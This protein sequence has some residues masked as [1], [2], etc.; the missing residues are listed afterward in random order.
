M[1]PLIKIASKLRNRKFSPSEVSAMLCLP[2]EHINNLFDEVDGLGI[3]E[4]GDGKRRI[5][6]R[7]LFTLLMAKRLIELGLAK[8]VRRRALGQALSKSTKRVEPTAELSVLVTGF[9]EQAKAA[10][11]SLYEAEGN[12][13][14]SGEI[15]QGEPCLRDTRVSVYVL[16]EI[17]AKHGIESARKTYSFLD[18]KQIEYAI[19]YAKARPRKGRPKTTMLPVEPASET[20][21][22]IVIRQKRK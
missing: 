16:A 21:K 2:V 18:Q 15:M 14:S 12:V 9:R 22:K 20:K 13:S 7:G 1:I 3:V 5:E 19:L 8:D 4:K 6:Y 10:L 17:A 11:S